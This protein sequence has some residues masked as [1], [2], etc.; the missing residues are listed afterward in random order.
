ARDAM[1]R[2]GSLVVCTDVVAAETHGVTVQPLALNSG[3]EPTPG[4]SQEG[5]TKNPLLGGDLGVGELLPH[6]N[7]SLPPN[8]EAGEYALLSVSDTGTGMDKETQ[9]RIFEPFFT[10]KE[11]GKGTGIGLSIVFGIIKQHRGCIDVTSKPGRGTTFKIYLPLAESGAEEVA[12]N[13]PKHFLCSVYGTE[14]ILVAEDEAAV[15]EITRKVLEEYGYKVIPALDGKEAVDKFVKN[16]DK[17][18]LLILDVKMPRK[19]GKEVY[20]AIKKIKP[21]M[22]A[23]FMS[24]NST[25]IINEKDIVEEGLSV[26]SKPFL[27]IELLRKVREALDDS[28]V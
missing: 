19:N 16:R 22:K 18:Q 12:E 5:N 20:A 2:G 14:T 11:V 28:I 3:E 17:V 13:N 27:P 9:E 21:D 4:P 24:G 10:T 6:G 23:I 25:D 26:I 7:T 1:P 8:C 15:M